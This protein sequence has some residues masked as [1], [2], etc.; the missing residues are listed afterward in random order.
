MRSIARLIPFVAAFG[1]LVEAS[2][3]RPSFLD[4]AHDGQQAASAAQ[5][6]VQESLYDL[7]DSVFRFACSDDG[8]LLPIDEGEA[9]RMEGKIFE[10][11]SVLYDGAGGYHYMLDT[12]PVGMRGIGLTS[13]EEFRVSE[14][15]HTVANN[16]LAGG[17]GAYRQTLKM[18][19]RDTQRTFWL[20][21]YGNYV[22]SAEGLIRTSRDVLRLE[23]KVR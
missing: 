14:S 17:V 21:A 20:V 6:T 12:M 15:S 19:G 8:E 22:I 10:R 3:P 9:V 1:I 7:S 11:L 4:A 16:R 2:E 23:C 13:G 18:V 5:R